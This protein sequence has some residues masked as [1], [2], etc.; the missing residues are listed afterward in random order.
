MGAM[1][2][3][4]SVM[5]G[6]L[7]CP[8]VRTHDGARLRSSLA[9]SKRPLLTWCGGLKGQIL[10]KNVPCHLK[11]S[12]WPLSPFTKKRSLLQL[13]IASTTAGGMV[14]H[15]TYPSPIPSLQ[16]PSMVVGR[17][18][19]SLSMGSLRTAHV[20]RKGAKGCKPARFTR[21]AY[22]PIQAL[23]TLASNGVVVCVLMITLRTS[24]P[25]RTIKPR[26]SAWV[27]EA[28]DVAQTDV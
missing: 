14:T 12:T 2:L 26:H 22:N 6:S 9:L 19:A 1:P 8:L 5:P 15:L 17:K 7:G 25:R 28:Q 11:L 13:S 23:L 24:S 16:V 10:M 20:V 4:L 27:W 18:N 3:V 21:H